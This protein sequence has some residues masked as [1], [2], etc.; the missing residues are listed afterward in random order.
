MTL[1]KINCSCAFLLGLA[2]IPVTDRIEID[3]IRSTSREQMNVAGH[4]KLIKRDWFDLC[5]Y[6]T[7]YQIW[8]CWESLSKKANMSVLDFRTF[9]MRLFLT[10]ILMRANYPPKHEYLLGIIV[11]WDVAAEWFRCANVILL[12][13][14]QIMVPTNELYLLTRYFGAGYNELNVSC[15]AEIH[16]KGKHD[17]FYCTLELSTNI[18]SAVLLYRM[19]FKLHIITRFT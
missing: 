15:N 1:S 13:R 6:R 19:Q 12:L 8:M 16:F 17:T 2:E 14:I 7:F 3:R 11:C 10:L 9:L 5:I 4:F 18:L